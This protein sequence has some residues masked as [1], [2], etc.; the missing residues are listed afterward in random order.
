MADTTTLKDKIRSTIYP[1]GKGA[2]NAADHQA[3]LLD[4]ADGIGAMNDKLNA[5]ATDTESNNVAIEDLQDNK[6]DR[7]GYEPDLSVGVA[8]HLAGH[9]KPTPSEFTFRKSGGGAILSGNARVQSAKGNSG[10]WNQK[11][12]GGYVH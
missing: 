1:N 4:M 6:A 12:D 8:D 7:G 3:L 9:D 5:V 2:I 10:G 11:E